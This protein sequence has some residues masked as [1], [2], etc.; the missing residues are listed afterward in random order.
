M[1]IFF[2][3]PSL[4]W[5]NKYSI[6]RLHM[7]SGQKS[8]FHLF[9]SNPSGFTQPFHIFSLHRAPTSS[10]KYINSITNWVWFFH[11][12]FARMCAMISK[13]NW[14]TCR[15]QPQTCCRQ[16]QTPT[17]WCNYRF[18]G[19][20]FLVLVRTTKRGRKIKSYSLVCC[21]LR[22]DNS[23]FQCSNKVTIICQ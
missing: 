9:Q 20:V 12:P 15:K 11:F 21:T 6:V 5:I 4:Q 1:N 23:V 19:S 2:G 8:K 10:K 22:R 7:A 3:S 18:F 14:L 17:C 16:I 13:W